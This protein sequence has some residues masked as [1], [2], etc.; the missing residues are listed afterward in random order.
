[1]KFDGY[2][3]NGFYDELMDASGKPRPEARLLIE[4]IEAQEDGHLLRF[5]RA[6]EL[7]LMQMGITFNVYGDS[8]GTERIFPFDLINQSRSISTG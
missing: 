3:T 8:S 5:Q 1:M 6:A 2:K 4:T 7:S